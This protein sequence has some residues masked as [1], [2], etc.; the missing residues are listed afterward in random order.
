MRAEW[1]GWKRRCRWDVLDEMLR[2]EALVVLP[3]ERES[4]GVDDE[5]ALVAAAQRDPHAFGPL[6]RHYLARVYRYVRAHVA[7]E[8]DAADLTQQVFLR[9]LDAMP[10]YTPRGVPF[11]AWLF[12]LARNTTI[13]AH[14]RQRPTVTWE[15]LPEALHPLAACEPEADVLQQEARARLRALLETLSQEQRD[16]LALRFAAQLS[17][18]EIA[19]VVG[20]SP[21]AVKKQLTRILHALKERYDDA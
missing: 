21:A 8:D 3:L 17:S 20:R 14:R 2:L 16:L 13:D 4:D 15:A 11:S 7:T 10:T 12:R 9:A 6:Y 18:A 5:S 19:G 1:T